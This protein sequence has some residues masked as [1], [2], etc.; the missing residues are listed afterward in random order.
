MKQIKRYL[1]YASSIIFSRGIEY[2]VLL[3]AAYYLSKHE[4][5]ELEF[6]KKCIELGSTFI[7]FGLPSLIM[8]YTRS[9]KSK[10]NFYVL[11]LIFSTTLACIFFVFLS[12]TPY[13]FLVI[14]FVFNAVFFT[15]GI[16]HSYILVLKGSVYAS[17][18]KAIISA[19]FYTVLFVLIYFFQYESLSYVYVSYVLIIPLIVFIFFEL[20]S[21][22][23]KTLIKI[24]SYL[25]LFRKLILGSL[26]LVLSNFIN[27]MFLYTDI[28]ILKFLSEDSNADIANYSFSL[29]IASVLLI[30]S[31]TIV[32]VEIENLKLNTVNVSKIN[33][34]I[35]LLTSV[36]TVGLIF[37]FLFL[38]EHLFFDFRETFVLFLIVI[39][40]KI[41]QSLSTFYGTMMVI[42]KKFKINFIINII[43]FFGNI[44]ISLI[45]FPKF[46][47][48]GIA[49]ASMISL[50][51]RKFTLVY[52][53]NSIIR[54]KH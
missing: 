37:G 41:F 48:Y 12:W 28:F 18:L 19:S 6:Y 20:K 44:F 16:T 34:R 9:S 38:T 7:A 4:Y 52:Y 53:F 33:N 30:I 1:I 27:I 45:L 8:S 21:Q 23:D 54:A 13:F 39:A 46:G 15:G 5:G 43:T 11:S 29:N 47:L 14:P 24:R 51:L 17:A 49:T 50:G 36:L 31:M 32:Q 22:Y 40:A 2:I 10:I 25:G 3:F 26:T 35:R 42:K